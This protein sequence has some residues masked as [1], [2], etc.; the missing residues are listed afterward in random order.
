MRQLRFSR[1]ITLG[2][3]ALVVVVCLL[4]F[5]EMARRGHYHL[6]GSR[7]WDLPSP[8]SVKAAQ[9][10]LHSVRLPQV[11]VRVV[12]HLS[13]TERLSALLMPP[14]VLPD[15]TW[16]WFGLRPPPEV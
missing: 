16:V 10:P 1:L 14:P 4:S 8:V 15:T 6:D 7:G 5:G 9:F 13:C 12:Q 2:A 11:V 3:S